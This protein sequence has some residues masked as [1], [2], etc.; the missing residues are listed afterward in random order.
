[1]E[2]EEI[3]KNIAAADRK[4]MEA[5]KAHWDNI[6]KPLDGLGLLEQMIIRISG[7]Q[8]TP[9]ISI[10]N[11]AIVVMCADNGVIAEGVAQSGNDVTAI[12]SANIAKGLASVNRMAGIAGARVVT[13]DIGVAQDI[14]APDLIIKKVARGT[15]NM[16]EGPAMTKEEALE[17]IHIGI[18]MVKSLKEEG[19]QILGTGEMG[20]GNTTSS[21]AIASVLLH[22]PV[23]EVTGKGAGLSKAGIL[24]K[25][26][27]IEQAIA[28]NKPEPG[29]ALDVLAKVGGLDI[30]GL[31]GVFLGGA[32]YGIPVVIDGLISG[33]AALIAAR[34]C[35]A[36]LDYM[37]P[38]HMSNEPSCRAL[39]KELGLEPIIHGRL[40]LGEGTGTALLFPMLDMAYEVYSENSTF[41]D[42]HIDAYEKFE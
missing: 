32:Y 25:A 33:I 8:R 38:S 13:V 29:D 30:A 18:D 5:S 35:P 36:A 41:E 1:M 26:A 42:V 3:I 22:M 23:K 16:A 17:A 2:M 21:S 28:L 7:I 40:A 14:S 37:L 4:S 10:K 6:A 9:D 11:K 24:H 34:L 27:V 12:V 39:M 19:I 15:K 20:I 31:T